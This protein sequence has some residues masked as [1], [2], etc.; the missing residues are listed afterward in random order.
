MATKVI[1]QD[2]NGKTT[3]I[4]MIIR[5]QGVHTTKTFKV[6]SRPRTTEMEAEAW[7]IQTEKDI[8]DGVFRK[9]E[10]KQNFSVAQAIDKY[11]AD[12]N[13]KLPEKTRK[14]HITALNWFKKEI[15]SLPIKQLERSDIKK[16]RDLLIKKPKA[17]PIKGKE[18]RTTTETISNSTVNRYLAYF[19][20]FLTHC[21]LEYEIIQ[22]NPMIGGKLKL[23]EN[24]ART[25]WL[26]TLEERQ[27]LLKLCKEKDYELYL[28]VLI[29]LLT[30]TRKME[31]LTLKWDNVD[32]ENKAL[33]FKKTKNGDDR[34]LPI[35]QILFD[36]LRRFRSAEKV[37]RL[38]NDYL[39]VNSNGNPREILVDKYYPAIIEN[40]EYTKLC[41]HELRHT[42]TSVASLLNINTDIID[43]ITGHRNGRMTA[44]YTHADCG[45]LREPMENIASY[46]LGAEKSEEFETILKSKC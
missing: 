43:K 34:T 13:P 33:Y 1:L 45:Y 6:G 14:A 38:K 32:F 16:C 4:K 9:E 39:F 15:G 28:C 24:D 23:K 17:V 30:G 2:K 40:W 25:E 41:F 26:K 5:M 31:I 7:A 20:G 11:I 8:I 42:F 19:S 44:R 21:M 46:I 29:A 12:G 36:E 37:R 10:K 27:L 22:F 35:P 3:R 18:G